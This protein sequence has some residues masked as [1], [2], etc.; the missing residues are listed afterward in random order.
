[1]QKTDDLIRKLAKLYGLEILEN[2]N[3]HQLVMEDGTVYSHNEPAFWDAFGLSFFGESTFI[4]EEGGQL[5]KEAEVTFTG[6]GV[7]Q[8]NTNYFNTNENIS[9][10]TNPGNYQYAMAA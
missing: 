8:P 5:I 3:S 10:N 9:T 7:Q 1:M 2:A 4:V 6:F